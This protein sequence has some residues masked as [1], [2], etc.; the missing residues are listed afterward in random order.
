MINTDSNPSKATTPPD[1]EDNFPN[2]ADGPFYVSEELSELVHLI[3]YLQESMEAL[4][5][6]QIVEY[7]KI[8]TGLCLLIGNLKERAERTLTKVRN[9]IV[10][11]GREH[12]RKAEAERTPE[13][14]LETDDEDNPIPEPE[15]DTSKPSSAETVIDDFDLD[16]CEKDKLHPAVCLPSEESRKYW[17]GGGK[18]MLVDEIDYME[19]INY[20]FHKLLEALFECD[21]VRESMDW[22][23]A[24][25]GLIQWKDWMR[26][27]HCQ[28][29]QT[30]IKES[31]KLKG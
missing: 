7:E 11:A 14:E 26:L 29:R 13:S 5:E 24:K 3:D 2:F 23:L 12:R 21:E 6:I 4:G 19:D 27:R 8:K 20:F 28:L 10:E 31:A 9:Q 22:E 16:T 18:T 15:T 25:H 30:A 17:Y 1:D